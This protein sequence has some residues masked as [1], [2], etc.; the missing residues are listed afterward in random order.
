MPPIPTI[1]EPEPVSVP[2]PLS[3]SQSASGNSKKSFR[4]AGLETGSHLHKRVFVGPLPEKAVP[5]PDAAPGKGKKKKRR[6]RLGSSDDEEDGHISRIIREHAFAFFIQE[7]GNEEDW[8]ETREQ[9][10]R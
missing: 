1:V 10:V 2:P 7:G 5:L 9:S 6:L 4:A 3:K 8:E